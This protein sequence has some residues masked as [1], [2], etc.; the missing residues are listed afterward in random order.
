MLLANKAKVNQELKDGTTPLMKAIERGQ[1][2]IAE[3]LINKGAEVDKV[4]NNGDTAHKIAEKK[5]YKDLSAM[6][7]TKSLKVDKAL[8]RFVEKVY[9]SKQ[10]D[11]ATTR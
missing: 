3:I 5:G 8:K 6:L 11:K 1:I 4:N 9:E 10:G 7:E 2:K